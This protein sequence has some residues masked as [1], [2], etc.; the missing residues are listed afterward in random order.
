MKRTASIEHKASVVLRAGIWSSGIL[1]A[2][3]LL[4]ALLQGVGVGASEGNTTISQILRFAIADPVH[5]LTILYAGLLVLMFTPILRVIAALVG[6]AE[7]GDRRFVAVSAVVFV[8]LLCEIGYSFF[9][10]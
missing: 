5:P 9:L 2:L 1:M 8:L 4:L 10:K 3:G 6:F 7:E